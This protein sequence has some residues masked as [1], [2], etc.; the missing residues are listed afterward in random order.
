[1]QTA[2][3]FEFPLGP[4]RYWSAGKNGHGRAVRFCWSSRANDLGYYVGWREVDGPETKTG[5]Q[6]QIRER[7]C[8]RK[9]KDVAD[10]AKEKAEAYLAA[11]FERVGTPFSVTLE[12]RR[13]TKVELTRWMRL[14]GYTTPFTIAAGR[15]AFADQTIADHFLYAFR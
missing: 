10:W 6:V 13:V 12:T 7:V 4:W 11:Q 5:G 15:Y 9:R 8:R 3:K 2:P 1:M 14:S